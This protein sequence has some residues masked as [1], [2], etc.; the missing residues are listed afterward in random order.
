[1]HAR[2]LA[3]VPS[4][5]HVCKYIRFISIFQL[6]LQEF[7]VVTMAI[8]LGVKRVGPRVYS[9]WRVQQY[10]FQHALI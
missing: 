7:E 4:Y 3:A 2:E 1:M 5:M 8:H 6:Y 9:V 10:T